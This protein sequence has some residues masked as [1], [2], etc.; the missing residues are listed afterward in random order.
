MLQEGSLLPSQLVEDT[1]FSVGGFAPQ[2]Y[3][4]Q[5][6]GAAPANLALSRSRNVPAV[7]MLQSY[8]VARFQDDLRRLG[9]TTLHRAPNDYGLTLILGGAEVRLWELAGAYRTLALAALDIDV[10]STAI[11]ALEDGLFCGDVDQH[12]ARHAGIDVALLNDGLIVAVPELFRG[13][14]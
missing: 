2:N 7:R 14:T 13:S 11:A 6:V 5:Y 10:L 3:D 1:P 9:L 8:G 4:K 12:G